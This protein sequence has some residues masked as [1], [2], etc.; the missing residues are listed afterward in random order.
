MTL[1]R[2][3][4]LLV[5]AAMLALLAACNG[6][7]PAPAPAAMP[8]AP[9]QPAPPQAAPAGLPPLTATLVGDCNAPGGY[10]LDSS[11]FTPGGQ[12]QTRATYSDGR[13]YNYLLN[14]G[15][16]VA[17]SLGKTPAWS[18]NC[19][20]GPNNRPDAAGDY[21]IEIIDLATGRVTPL[22]TLTVPSGLPGQ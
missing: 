4:L 18:W 6:G 15:I 21:R 5:S 1:A 19:L 22:I 3:L 13:P 2:K 14:G 12:Y 16:G 11:G 7:D 9:V 8:S 20:D 17:D 10:R